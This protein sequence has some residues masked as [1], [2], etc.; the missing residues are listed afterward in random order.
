MHIV[1]VELEDIKRYDSASYTFALG[2]NAISGPNGAGKSTILEAIGYALFDTL[3][4]K[5]E[6]F[7]RKGA[8]VGTVRV[9]FESG[10]DGRAYTVVRN[11]RATYYVYDPQTKTKLAE[12]KA[13]VLSWLRLHLG[14]EPDTDLE[15]LF[16]TAIGVPQGTF[17]AIFAETAVRRKA[18]FDRVLRVEEYRKSSDALKD[19]LAHLNGQV[20]DVD[21]K[22]AGFHGQ[23]LRLPELERQREQL[24]LQLGDATRKLSGSRNELALWKSRLAE[25]DA[26]LERMQT[27]EN[28]LKL[29]TAQQEAASKEVATHAARVAEARLASEEA[30]KAAPDHQ[31]YQ[32]AEAALKRLS[33]DRVKREEIAARQAEALREQTVLTA[34]IQ[35][36]EAQLRVLEAEREEF[37]KLAPQVSEQEAL[38]REI[39]DLERQVAEAAEL[40]L[41]IA[42]LD[43]EL[44][45][46]QEQLDALSKELASLD[47]LRPEAERAPGLETALEA[48]TKRHAEILEVL[49]A[50]KEAEQRLTMLREALAKD[51]K[52]HDELVPQITKKA[53]LKELA[54]QEPEIREKGQALSDQVSRLEGALER[55]RKA[56][57]DFKGGNACPILLVGCP[58][59]EGQTAAEY[60]AAQIAERERE[61]TGHKRE[62]DALRKRYAEVK[63]A[64][65]EVAGLSE[66]ERQ[67]ETLGASLKATEAQIREVEAQRRVKLEPS[68]LEQAQAEVKQ[69]T[70]AL[71]QAQA[72]ALRL[73]SRERLAGQ[74]ESLAAESASRKAEREAAFKRVS[75]LAGAKSTLAEREARLKA[76]GDPRSRHGAIAKNLERRPELER[77]REERQMSERTTQERL[78]DLARELEPFADLDARWKRETLAKEATEPG[79]RRFLT[80]STT[81]NELPMREASH[82]EA[83]T[84]LDALSEE[85][86]KVTKALEGARLAYRQEDHQALRDRV[87]AHAAEAIR[88]EQSVLFLEQQSATTEKEIA[89]LK[90]IQL[91]LAESLQERER[92]AGLA[93]FVEFARLTL[94]EAGPFITEAYLLNISLEAD[95]LFRDITGNHHV[96]LRWNSDYEI[97]LEEDGRER[98]F[99]SLSGGEQMAAALSV[100]L[101]LL[102][103]MSAIDIAFFDEPTTNMDENR[104]QNLAFSIGELKG[105]T[106][107]VVI[108][109]DDTFEQWTDHVVRVG[110]GVLTQS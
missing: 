80:L 85:L 54:S 48:A 109:H 14:V 76:L 97:L 39:R 104:R 57:A 40:E 98:P 19:T 59:L 58:V 93:A 31:A 73:E 75:E 69:L 94:K 47:A 102:K 53:Q 11:T 25:T 12:Q 35:S 68:A 105:F 44:A 45:T 92:L 23:L 21:M 33:E 79:Y 101:A 55:D 89:D 4:Y 78:K 38:E 37:D 82:A 86:A 8:K 81:A 22:L 60:F 10:L 71:K 96:H 106:Q 107:L 26:M 32:E 84:R 1:S 28:R 110:G 56:Q 36:L 49:Q 91:E 41:A 63:A 103:E 64:E 88:M 2:T 77:Q 51:Q 7:L 17:T 67:R 46:R 83:Q 15:E 62:R 108:S 90:R 95:R 24:A 65:R 5:K 42:R 34:E 29:V 43:K 18:V 52:Q 6:D 72:A 66:L 99:A 3:P 70:E 9:T 74:Q 100:R 20:N 13:D 30:T 27:E 16:R 61:I 50:Q 87:E